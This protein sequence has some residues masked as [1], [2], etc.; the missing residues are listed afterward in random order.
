[1]QSVCAEIAEAEQRV[2]KKDRWSGLSAPGAVFLVPGML[3]HNNLVV[4]HPF[5]LLPGTGGTGGG[6]MVP[7]RGWEEKQGVSTLSLPSPS[8][9]FCLATG[10]F[11]A[12]FFAPPS[13]N[14]ALSRKTLPLILISPGHL[15]LISVPSY[16]REILESTRVS[17]LATSIYANL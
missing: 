7:F 8:S 12:P 3:A 15:A 17:A 11:S 1:M 9:V 16:Q 14:Q 13:R 4:N 6:S 5:S 2:I 10:H